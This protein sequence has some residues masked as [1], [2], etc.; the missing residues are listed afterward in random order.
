MH[1]DSIRVMGRAA[2]GVRLINLKGSA[3]IAAVARVPRSDEE[4]E[5]FDGEEGTIID[6]DGPVA[7]SEE[8][9]ETNSEE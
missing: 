5:E 9:N 1:I 7:D 3:A 4:D 8:T 2:Q 6:G